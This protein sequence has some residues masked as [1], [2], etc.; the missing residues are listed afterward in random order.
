MAFR[1]DFQCDVVRVDYNFE[2]EYGRAWLQEGENCDMNGCIAF[3]KAIDPAV[4]HI[5]TFSGDQ[6]DTVYMLRSGDW[7]AKARD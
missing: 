1:E 5:E 2:R 4:K 3:F 6:E 7:I